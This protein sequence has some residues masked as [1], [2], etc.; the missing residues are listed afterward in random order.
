[1]LEIA[2]GSD[3]TSSRE[4]QCHFSQTRDLSLFLSLLETIEAQSTAI[5]TNTF[6]GTN[7]FHVEMRSE[8]TITYVVV[9]DELRAKLSEQTLSHVVTSGS[10]LEITGGEELPLKTDPS[11]SLEAKHRIKGREQLVRQVCDL[12]E[13]EA[14]A[15]GIS[16]L[17]IQVRPL[18]SQE[19]NEQT[20]IVINAEV[21][22]TREEG[23]RYWDAVCERLNQLEG[24]VSSEDRRFLT[25]EI[26][27][28]VNWD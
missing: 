23:D 5:N 28:V 12:A 24:S 22:A 11:I 2:A 1:M 19:S 4:S 17:K 18:W 8:G 9:L 21:K 7:T 13:Q 20:G 27:F 10:I 25:N 6:H 3:K 15:R 14:R 26:F 16:L